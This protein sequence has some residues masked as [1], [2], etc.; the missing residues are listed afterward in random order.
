VGPERPDQTVLLEVARP[1]LEDQRAHLGEG[2]ALEI[3][4]LGELGP[5]GLGIA[6]EE[7][8]DGS[9][10]ERHREER[11]GDRI[12]QLAREMGALLARRELARPGA[13]ARARAGHAR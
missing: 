6:I 9:R 4:E 13:A 8:L 10:H 3:P 7:H 1:E 5:R 11:L 12:V 2:L